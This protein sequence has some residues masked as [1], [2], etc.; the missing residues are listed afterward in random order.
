MKIIEL[1]QEKNIQHLKLLNFGSG[2]GYGL[3]EL[4]EF[5][6]I[7]ISGIEID[8]STHQGSINHLKRCAK[9]SKKL[10]YLPYLP[11]KGNAM[12]ITFL[13]ELL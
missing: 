6:G 10:N 8:G 11:I 13:K 1:Y 2:I 5:S 9:K 3:E 12:E 7:N 4:H